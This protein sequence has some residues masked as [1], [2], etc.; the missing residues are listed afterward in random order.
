ME[1]AA[2][3]SKLEEDITCSV[4]L[5]ELADPVSITCGHTFCR[6]CI[7]DYW[8]TA[9]PQEYLCPECRSTC[10]KDQ[11]I[12]AY[13]LKHLVSKVQLAKEEQAKRERMAPASAVPLVY[14]DPH[15]QLQLDESV[16]QSCF[17]DGKIAGYPLCLIC[18][19]GEKRW[20]KSTLMNYILR[21]LHSLETQQRISLGELNDPLTGFAWLPGTDTITKGIWMWN[22]PFILKRNGDKMAVFVLDTEGSLDIESDRETCI[23]LSALSMLLSSYLIFNISAM[24]KTTEL[25]YLETYL[26]VAELTGKSFSLQPLQCLELLVRDCYD[27]KNCGRAAALTYIQK[28]KEK[29]RRSSNHG[30]VLQT[31]D[32]PSVSGFLLPH[33][34]KQFPTSVHGSLADMD[35]DFRSHLTGYITKLM[36][37]LWEHRKADTHGN[38]ITCAQVGRALKDFFRVLK[39]KS[40]GFKSPME[41]YYSLENEKTL[42]DIMKKFQD[43]LKKETPSSPVDVLKIKT[44]ELKK[45]VSDKIDT[46]LSV[47]RG[48]LQGDES[49]KQQLEDK[50][51]ADMKQELERLCAQHKKRYVKCAAGVG[52]A[53]GGVVLGVAGGAVGG[54]VA[55]TVLVAEAV[56]IEGTIAAGAAI[57]G[58]TLGAFGSWI[59][60]LIGRF[61]GRKKNENNQQSDREGTDD[62][63]SNREGTDAERLLGKQK[64]Q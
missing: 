14:T 24:L 48:R 59:G 41:M 15:G 47:Y 62:Q 25:D 5:Q 53:V 27:P 21:A 18:V 4:C 2:G 30:K 44:S 38:Q 11:L 54:A 58:G 13:R 60:H 23:K 51:R 17:L 49:K 1:A 43:L 8:A 3:F 33:P 37:E 9:Q 20:G 31:L 26:Y 57:G 6:A 55:G 56:A 64:K 10:P 29:L 36:R 46:L 22:K 12:P 52:L 19:I 34:G 63:E 45:K 39:N 28:E 42:D 7:T 35:E 40:Y 16:I 61:F 50:L 32:S